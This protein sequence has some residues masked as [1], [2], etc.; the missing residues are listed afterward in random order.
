MLLYGVMILT[1]YILFPVFYW[2][3]KWLPTNF[4]Y[5]DSEDGIY[6]DVKWRNERGYNKTF[7]TALRWSWRNPVWG[8]W[9]YFKVKQ[10]DKTPIKIVD[11][12]DY[13]DWRENVYLPCQIKTNNGNF[14][15]DFNENTSI[16]GHRFVVYKVDNTVY[17][18]WSKAYEI[19]PFNIFYEFELGYNNKRYLLNRNRKKLITTNN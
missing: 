8:F 19:R 9:L 10:G 5:F 4:I 3:K 1:S 18:N 14:G 13:N 2:F 17:W 6:G 16:L 11:K 15:K 12:T 7:L